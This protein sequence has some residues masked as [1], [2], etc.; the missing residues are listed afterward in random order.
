MDF[1]TIIAENLCASLDN[2]RAN[3]LARWGK[4]NFEVL[5]A[6]QNLVLRE[7]AR[8]YQ[9]GVEDVIENLEYQ[10]RRGYSSCGD[11]RRLGNI[12][13]DMLAQASVKWQLENRNFLKFLATAFSVKI[14]NLLEYEESE[15]ILVEVGKI[16]GI[17]RD[18]AEGYQI[19]V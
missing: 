17:L 8:Q 12:Q 5:K 4:E 16:D 19:A 13:D 11:C 1:H 2:M 10:V 7:M 6:S 15:E 3:T 18:I 14:P 9:E